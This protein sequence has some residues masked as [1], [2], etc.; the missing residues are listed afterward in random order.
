M[1]VGEFQG[2]DHRRLFQG[3]IL[4]GTMRLSPR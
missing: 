3:H 2:R 1:T 4:Q